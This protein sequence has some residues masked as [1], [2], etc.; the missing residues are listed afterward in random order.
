[1]ALNGHGQ[2]KEAPAC[3]AGAS[4]VPAQTAE[5]RLH[6]ILVAGTYAIVTMASESGHSLLTIE[7]PLASC[8]ARGSGDSD[9][10]DRHRLA[11][12]AKTGALVPDAPFLVKVGRADRSGVYDQEPEVSGP[13]MASG[14]P[15]P[16]PI[17]AAS[18]FLV[19]ARD[20]LHIN[21]ECLN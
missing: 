5:N 7:T 15:M 14:P 13:P 16:D 4:C 10:R 18:S 9:E 6:S 8:A 2:K 19:L 1:V 12:D 21:D 11:I 17:P 3:G 20:V